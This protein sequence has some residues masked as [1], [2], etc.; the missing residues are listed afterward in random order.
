MR[1]AYISTNLPIE[2]VVRLINVGS[3]VEFEV[4][5]R[6]GLNIGGGQYFRVFDQD[7]ELVLCWSE[8]YAD[9]PEARFRYCLYVRRG[10]DNLLEQAAEQVSKQGA[11]VVIQ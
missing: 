3:F 9:P 11:D 10:S 1:F 6:E 5:E 7:R 2:S 8:N 4:E